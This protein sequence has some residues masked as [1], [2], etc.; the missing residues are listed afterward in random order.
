MPL[1]RGERER[2]RW[3]NEKG[4]SVGNIHNDKGRER[5]RESV[6]LVWKVRCPKG[7]NETNRCAL[8]NYKDQQNYQ[9]PN[10]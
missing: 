3:E 1:C 7:T 2:E 8:E 10:I 4:F 6:Y 9:M 5:E